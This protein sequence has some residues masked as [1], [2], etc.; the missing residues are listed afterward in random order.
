MILLVVKI[1]DCLLTVLLLCY[2]FGKVLPKR[3]FGNI[4]HMAVNISCVAMFSALT[5]WLLDSDWGPLLNF[6]GVIGFVIIKYKTRF[7]K[8]L[9]LS[10]LYY[11]L[12]AFADVLIVII[13]ISA[14]SVDIHAVRE[15]TVLYL[16]VVILSK[17]LL[18]GILRLVGSFRLGASDRLDPKT[19]VA[20][21]GIT[22]LVAAVAIYLTMIS[23][24]IQ[25]GQT[26]FYIIT[27]LIML[28]FA[29][30]VT[31]YLLEKQKN[32][33]ETQA[34]MKNMAGQYALQAAYYAELKN[35]LVA[36]N[37]NTHDIK[38]FAT[39]L[40]AYLE[41]GKTAE[42]KER[43]NEFIDRIPATST[44]DT[45]NTA[46]NALL[47]AKTAAL[48]KIAKNSLSIALPPTLAID[49]IDLCVII[50]N[51]ID[52]ALEACEKIENEGDRYINIKIFPFNN[53][54]SLL[55]ENSCREKAEKD[56][57]ATDKP[58][59]FMHGFGIENMRALCDKY[60]GN[61]SFE[62][63]GGKFSVSILLPN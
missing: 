20:V 55:F 4:A 39:A 19:V 24:D 53:C 26:A 15:N 17:L 33:Y 37:K 35:N 8:G 56:L 10:V 62:Q 30:V 50:G 49:E 52:N 23:Y 54:L 12:A 29:V 59:A 46:I 7:L 28:A 16:Y 40:S 1:F 11:A 14:L 18:Y 57:F 58:Q 3:S 63:V 22:V 21:I 43:L 42:A 47:H 6:A 51:A 32:I 36:T 31:F 60:N 34:Y 27:I 45:G 25:G 2:F 48:G 13:Q 38:N 9:L 61:I 5:I 41:A 44:I